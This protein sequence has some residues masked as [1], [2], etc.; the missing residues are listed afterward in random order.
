MTRTLA[1]LS[2]NLRGVLWMTGAMAS[3]VFVDV[4][5][6]LVSADIPTA[7]ILAMRAILTVAAFLVILMFVGTRQ[8]R[9][10]RPYAHMLRGV[11]WYGSLFCVFY[12]LRQMSISEVNAYLFIEALL[13]VMLAV[14]FL[15]EKLTARKLA[16]TLLGLVG[17]WIMC[18]P[19]MNGFGVPLGV[20]GALAGAF[21]FSAQTLF[22]KVLTR[23]ETNFSMLFWPQIVAV[24]IW[25]PVGVILWQPAALS[26]W[27][28]A[29]GAGFFAMLTNYMVLRAVRVADASVISPAAYTALPFSLAMDLIFFDMFPMP[30]IFVGAG[31]VVL[32]VMLLDFKGSAKPAPS[33]DEDEDIAPS[34]STKQQADAR[35]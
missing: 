3:G 32:A 9:T 33:A 15:G 6:K 16:A 7:Q 10:R 31:L 2:G 14:V 26:D 13:T 35:V 34:V 30:I 5:A 4:C 11:L 23:T 19:K 29:G 18:A 8:V 22:A 20:A 1:R 12:A 27:A 25:V 17:V 21:C 24:V 28:F